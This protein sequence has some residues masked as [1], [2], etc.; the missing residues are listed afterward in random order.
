MARLSLLKNK[1]S[2]AVGISFE[3]N[4][5]SVYWWLLDTKKEVIA[6]NIN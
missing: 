2:W 5:L 4:K 3:A 1:K 6:G